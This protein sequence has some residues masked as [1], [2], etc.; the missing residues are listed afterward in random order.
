VFDPNLP[1]RLRRRLEARPEALI[2]RSRTPD[3]ERRKGDPRWY[4]AAVGAL[5]LSCTAAYLTGQAPDAAALGFRCL[6]TAGLSALVWWGFRRGGR[7][8]GVFSLLLA[9]GP[10]FL[11][12]AA[13]EDVAVTGANAFFWSAGPLGTLALA[14]KGTPALAVRHFDSYLIPED[15]HHE[16]AALL[17]RLQTAI[18]EARQAHGV[19]GDQLESERAEEWIRR[20]EW[21]IATSL[22]KSSELQ[23]D[24][25]S[26]RRDAVSERVRASLH[27]QRQALET[28]RA[29]VARR[30]RRFEEYAE[31]ASAA[32][33]TLLE[34]RQIEENERRSTPY[35]DLMTSATA[36]GT[37]AASEL[38]DGGAQAMRHSLD[39]QIREAITAGTWLQEA[40]ELQL[41]FTEEDSE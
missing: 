31:L 13:S 24:L 10:L 26:R 32:A 23:E 41:R 16:E 1:G 15:F 19:L 21:S 20:H 6:S 4:G 8:G 34:L 28:A 36:E 39:Q 7:F 30:V 12:W 33:K 14:L 3:P 18:D 17:A 27:P 2:P 35:L 25:D 11:I 37:P 40:S 9:W 22:A 38:D 29:A 5:A